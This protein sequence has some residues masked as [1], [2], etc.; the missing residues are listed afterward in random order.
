M[1]LCTRGD[2]SLHTTSLPADCFW[3][4]IYC[5]NTFTNGR[6]NIIEI[7]LGNVNFKCSLEDLVVADDNVLLLDEN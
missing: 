2:N 4:H 6:K 3:F 1:V 7:L 5:C